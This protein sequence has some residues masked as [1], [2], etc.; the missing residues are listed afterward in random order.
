M[1]TLLDGVR[2]ELVDSAIPDEWAEQEKQLRQL[3]ARS[4]TGTL[5]FVLCLVGLVTGQTMVQ[6]SGSTYVRAP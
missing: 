2:R 5:F 4:T 6:G 1:A 3:Q